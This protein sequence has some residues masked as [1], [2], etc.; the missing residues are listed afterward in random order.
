MVNAEAAKLFAR[1]PEDE[2]PGRV[3]M[4]AT[5]CYRNNQATSVRGWVEYIIRD[6]SMEKLKSESANQIVDAQNATYDVPRIECTIYD[7][8]YNMYEILKTIRLRLK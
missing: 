8:Y 3:G 6:H 1:M 5:L 7:E 2:V 4:K